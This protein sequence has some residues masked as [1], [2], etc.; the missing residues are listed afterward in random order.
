MWAV[1]LNHKPREYI[2]VPYDKIGFDEFIEL[3]YIITN[4]PWDRKILHPMIAFFH[5]TKR[6]LVIV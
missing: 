2:K 6:Y 3:D 4:P 5:T 1:T